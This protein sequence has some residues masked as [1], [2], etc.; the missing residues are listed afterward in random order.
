MSRFID[1]LKQVSQVVSQPVGFR[2]SQAVPSKPKMLLIASL[3]EAN[4]DSLASDVAGADAGLLRI[5]KLNSGA[6]TLQKIA[7]AM[8]EIPWGGWLGESNQKGVEQLVKA[9]CDFAVFPAAGTSLAILQDNEVGKILELE[10]SLNEGSLRAVNELPVDA[11]LIAGGQGQDEF[12]TWYHLI[13]YQRFANSLT[14]PLLACIPPKVTATELQALW[15]ANISGVIIEVEAGQPDRLK[16]VRQTID[17]L[18]FVRRTRKKAEAFLP[19]VGRGET[20]IE[21]EEEEE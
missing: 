13:L 11:V 8:P 7:Q 4:M 2:L 15:E 16:E 14:K 3:V 5:P 18:S 12:L 1:K 20:E 9:G 17:K 10:P 6:K 19:Y 21:T